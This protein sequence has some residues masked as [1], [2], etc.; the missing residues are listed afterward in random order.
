MDIAHAGEHCPPAAHAHGGECLYRKE[1]VRHA[2][3]YH[4]AASLPEAPHSA[5]AWGNRTHV[6]N[7]HTGS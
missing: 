6:D 7:L 5:G 1:L 4:F 2:E 3:N